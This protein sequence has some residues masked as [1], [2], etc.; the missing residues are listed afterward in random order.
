[1]KSKWF[2]IHS[3]R[4]I[5]LVE[6][7]AS[8]AILSLVILT[9]LP[10]FTQSMRSA[11]VASDMLDSTYLAQSTLE[12]VYHLTTAYPFSE[13]VNHVDDMTFLGTEDEWYKYVQYKDGT[14]IELLIE[15][16][17]N[18]LSNVLVKVYSDDTKSKLEA[19]METVYRWE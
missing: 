6:I 10:L 7:I 18:E 12:D 3:E 15:E 2:K 13:A 5:T 1:M 14:Y 4:G 17:D 8:I 19:Q 9:F 16:P 11:K